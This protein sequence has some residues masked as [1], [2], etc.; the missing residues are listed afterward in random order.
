MADSL[1]TLFLC[2]DVMTGR[3]IDQVLPF[4]C[5]P[6]LHEACLKDARAYVDLAR[7]ASGSIFAP[8][9]FEYPWGDALAELAHVQPDARIVNLET[10]ITRSDD[11]W[12][13][14]GVN[15]R[16]SPEN[17]RC[18]AAA[19]IDVCCL[20]N[21]HVLDWGAAG[22]DDTLATL[23][24]LG[25]AHAGAGRT[26]REAQRPAVIDLGDRGRITVFAFGSGT[27]GV[28]AAWQATEH[29]AGVNVLPDLPLAGAVAHIRALVE[30]WRGAR[31]LVVLSIHWGSNW[32][33]HISAEE[34][35]LAHSLIDDAGIDVI[36][37][38]SSHH[39]KGIEVYRGRPILYGCGDLLTD[40]EGIQG[41]EAYRGG[42]GLM[43][44][45]TL[46][47]ATGRLQ[48]FRMTPTQMHR[49]QVKHA[50]D[51]QARWLEGVLRR[52]GNELGASADLD[53]D[54]QLVLCWT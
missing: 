3:G 47:M 10:S 33:Y 43:Y 52:E 40:Y 50:S 9:S 2:G 44:F 14:K 5:E 22:L 24:R 54:G 15:Y 37:G 6:T 46:D 31:D 21:N 39:V 7:K 16:M 49:L 42:L 38:H 17:A 35:R 8:V 26:L 4:P 32:E 20:A 41:Y 28:P 29:E 34:R 51:A 27:A 13:G 25:M 23:D 11:C 53:E 18:L 45:P 48:R 30:Q 1:V 12:P 36:H 19:N